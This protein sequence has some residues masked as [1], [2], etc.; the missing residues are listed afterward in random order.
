MQMNRLLV[1]LAP[2]GRPQSALERARWLAQ[3]S[4]VQIDLLYVDFNPVFEHNLLLSRH[5]LQQARDGYLQ[6]LNQWL[7][8]LAQPLRQLG[9]NV[10]AHL[11]WGSPQHE[12]VLKHLTEHPADLIFKTHHHPNFLERLHFGHEDWQL[13]RHCREPLWLTRETQQPVKHI[14][15]ALDPTHSADKP[16]ALDHAL[17]LAARELSERLN[18]RADYLHCHQPLPPSLLFDAE[19]MG[20]Y[21]QYQQES[22][23]QHR[24]ALFELTEHYQLPEHSVHFLPGLPEEVLPAFVEQQGIDLLLMGAISRSKFKQLLLGHTAERLME[25]LPCDLLIL[26]PPALTAE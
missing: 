7:H 19:L 20:S 11:R 16:A 26:K 3:H 12:E 15:A 9:L 14:A 18:L 23:E 8:G 2:Q 25:R 21:P 4:G 22:L 17:I 6:E 24:K 1:L 5:S 10:N 13:L